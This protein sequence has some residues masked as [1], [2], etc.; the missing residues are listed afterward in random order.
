M[1]YSWYGFIDR[2]PFELSIYSTS[3]TE[4][5][6]K[7]K[8][9]I[10]TIDSLS[11]QYKEVEE[12]YFRVCTDYLLT[13]E[14]KDMYEMNMTIERLKNKM[15]ELKNQIQVNSQSSVFDFGSKT[16][17]STINYDVI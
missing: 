15:K 14:E 2:K 4:A 8:Q 10:D 16:P 17:I 6:L 7:I 5:R 9:M 1:E 13:D 11:S 3:L 12:E